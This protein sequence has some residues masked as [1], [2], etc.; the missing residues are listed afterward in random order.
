M[1]NREVIEKIANCYGYE[2]QSRQCIEEMAELTQAI[3]KYWRKTLECGKYDYNPWDGFMTKSEQY[4]NLVEEIADVE[5][6]IE[7]MKYLLSCEKEVDYLIE[8]KLN[9]QLERIEEHSP[10]FT[11]V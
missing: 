4:S 5:I 6:M 2:A 9:R 11:I 10:F 7:E 8:Q 1:M 3:N